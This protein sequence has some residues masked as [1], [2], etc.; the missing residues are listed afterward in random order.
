[1]DTL[2]EICVYAASFGYSC[3]LTDLDALGIYRT[4]ALCCSPAAQPP[5]PL[6]TNPQSC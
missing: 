5:P 2:G 6:S 3:L 1:M 4:Q